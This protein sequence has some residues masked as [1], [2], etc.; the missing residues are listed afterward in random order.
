MSTVVER[1]DTFFRYQIKNPKEPSFIKVGNPDDSD[2]SDDKPYVWHRP[3]FFTSWRPSN[4]VVVLCFDLPKPDLPK[5][6]LTPPPPSLKE[7]LSNRLLESA[8]SLRLD[9][10]FAF[11]AVLIENLTTKFD[12]SVWSWR[13]KI[14]VIEK[15]RI[16]MQKQ[17]ALN[18][19]RVVTR[20]QRSRNQA[21]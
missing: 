13:D 16:I 12:E 1:I 19:P 8:S 21:F 11:H 20:K 2:N 3:G 4:T 9:D 15:V 14:R 18:V 6:G 17:T 5:P 10:P 7:M